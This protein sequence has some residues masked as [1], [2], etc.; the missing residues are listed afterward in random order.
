MLKALPT[1]IIAV[2]RSRSGQRNIRALVRFFVILGVMIVA[3]SVGF[4]LL[5]AREGQDHTWLTGLY[6][7]LTVMS[8]LGFGDITFH[9]D[10]G[11]AFSI[12]VLMSGM[13]F[14]LILLPFTFIEFFYAPWMAAQAHARAPRELPADQTGHVLL[15]NYG[16]VAQ[17]TIKRLE[18]Y[19]IDYALVVPEVDEALRYHDMH[20][21]VMVGELDDPDTWRRA[22]ADRAALVMTCASDV[23]NTNVAFTV[24]GV[25]ET[26]QI[27]STATEQ[28][29]VD[30]LELAGAN[31]VILLEDTLARSFSRR[32]TGG[33]ALAHEIG[34]FDEILIAEAT[35]RRT[36]LAGKTLLE[37]RVRENVGVTVVG[38]WE[39]GVFQPA[40]ADTPIHDNTVLVLAGS[41]EQ[42]ERYD[43]LFC[44]YNVSNAPVLILGGGRVGRATAD[45]LAERDVDYRIV[46]VQPELVRDPQKYIVG[47]AADLGVLK[48][49]GIEDAPTVIITP[50][51]DDLN[52]YLTLYCRKLRP[53]IQ[54]LTRATLERNVSTLHR[55]GAD[56]VMSYASMAAETAMN[57]LRRASILMVAEGLDLFKVR[58]PK[59]LAGKTIGESGIRE[60]T[61]CTLVAIGTEA[62]MQIVPDPTAPI[63]ADAD[64]LLVG[65]IDSEEA[66]LERYYESGRNNGEG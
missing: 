55:A 56:I 37:S 13:I 18:R 10:I 36:P 12:L 44:I 40:Q 41:R 31:H 24:R 64:L 4:H 34:Q 54:I 17:A 8:T 59:Q 39:R 57:W 65:S 7:T 50:H 1:E 60:T 26:V 21:N 49:A 29:S 61:G 66:F 53:D 14:L 58:V 42:L 28:A 9:T 6:W 11:R 25:T 2:V 43:E 38:V 46:E 52:T 63:P 48:K 20:I 33:D 51:E 15:T 22:G 45:A 5:M 47:D 35:A 23:V 62:G 19:G 32:V 16:S 27:V 3:Y 30:V